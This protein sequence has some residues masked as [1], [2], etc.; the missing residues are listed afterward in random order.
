MSARAAVNTLQRDP[1][2]NPV[3]N[4]TVIDC[5]LQS[6]AARLAHAPL[7]RLL[8]LLGAG[9]GLLLLL[10]FL[11]IVAALIA[12]ESPGNPLFTQRR[13]GF[14]GAPFVIYKF[15]TMRVR[16]GRGDDRSGRP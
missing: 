2:P 1:A 8:D 4:W 9:L 6:G 10:P 15:R 5:T 12:L 11:L 13:T 3:S 7:K 14:G 16:E